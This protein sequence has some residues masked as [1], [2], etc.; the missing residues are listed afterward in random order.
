[1]TA[2]KATHDDLLDEGFTAIQFNMV[3]A[4]DFNTWLDK[5]LLSA[6]LWVEQKCGVTVY[7]ALPAGSYA[8]DCARKAEVAYASAVL[9]RRRYIAVDTSVT[10]GLQKDQAMLLAELRRKETAAQQDANY[11]LGEA[12]RA[13]GVDDAALYDG[14]GMASGVVETGRYPA[15]VGVAS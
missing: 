7:A 2:P 9:Y 3:A 5:V 12:M 13:S 6:S 10:N 8:E 4:V 15:T 1:M 11:W 14:S